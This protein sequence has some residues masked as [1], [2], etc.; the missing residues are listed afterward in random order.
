M[1]DDMA[2]LDPAC[3]PEVPPRDSLVALGRI[4][5]AAAWRG[6]QG[7]L[8]RP[9]TGHSNRQ[10]VFGTQKSFEVRRY[11]AKELHCE[12]TNSSE[13]PVGRRREGLRFR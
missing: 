3:P 5:V 10:N 4:H 13:T 11:M 12:S 2:Q 8:S 6:L 1:C 7:I 9:L